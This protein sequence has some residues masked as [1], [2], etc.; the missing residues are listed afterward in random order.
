MKK[1]FEQEKERIQNDQSATNM[2]TD[3]ELQI[4]RK[5]LNLEKEHNETTLA[6]YQIDSTERIYNRIGVKEMKINQ[7]TGDMKTNLMSILPMMMTGL[8]PRE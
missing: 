4:A 2:K 1:E 3:F 6:K 5:R 7:F 8:I